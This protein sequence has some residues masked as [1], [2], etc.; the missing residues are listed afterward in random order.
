M[1]CVHHGR[2]CGE[3]P[4]V[5]TCPDGHRYMVRRLLGKGGFARVFRVAQLVREPKHHSA[6]DANTRALENSHVVA[7]ARGEH[8]SLHTLAQQKPLTAAACKHFALKVIS[9][10]RLGTSDAGRDALRNEVSIHRELKHPSIVNISSYW[11]DKYRIYLLLDLIEGPTLEELVRSRRRLAE[12]VAALYASQ[13]LEAMSYL[14]A[15]RIIH[16]DLK[17]ANVLLSK[18]LRRAYVCDFGLAIHSDNLKGSKTP[19][20][21]GTA[22]YFA[23]EVLTPALMSRLTKGFHSNKLSPPIGHSAKSDLWSMGV[24]LFS[25]LIG[26]GPFD[27]ED[28]PRTLRRI[29]TARFTFPIDIRL[30][31][32]AKSLVR[33][34]L[35]EDHR[36]R[37]TADEALQF[38]FFMISDQFLR[39]FVNGPIDEGRDSNETR[40]RI[41]T[42]SKRRDTPE[43]ANSVRSQTRNDDSPF[44]ISS[45][46]ESK[47]RNRRLS[48]PHPGHSNHSRERRISRNNQARL[49]RACHDRARS[50]N[51]TLAPAGRSDRRSSLA[52][53][54][55]GGNFSHI[56]TGTV[57]ESS[58]ISSSSRR[59]SIMETGMRNDTLNL[60]VT[61]SAALLK[62]RKFLDDDKTGSSPIGK[63]E[64]FRTVTTEVDGKKSAPPLVRRWMDYTSKYGFA[65]LMEDGRVGCCFN[66][67][68]IMFFVSEPTE[69][70]DVAYMPPLGT[71][72]AINKED[73]QNSKQ[74]LEISKKVCLCTLFADMIMDGGRGS[75]YDLPSACNVSFLK[76]DGDRQS[77]IPKAS[78]NFKGIVHVRDWARFRK[79]RATAFRLSNNNIHVKFDVGEDRCDD[80]VFSAT[81]STLFYR[82]AHSGDAFVCS[83]KHLGEFSAHSEYI[84]KQLQT[85]SRAITKFLE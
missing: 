85:C 42:S 74:Q 7:S 51:H 79:C 39:T 40:S 24:A 63:T 20:V 8:G 15:N 12:P 84:Y 67:G 57:D 35:T 71:D 64:R 26:Y 76:P 29:R 45:S 1:R 59:S 19:S 33:A 48:T 34:L 54:R 16:R 72:V 9:K 31:P 13:M 61:L 23:P 49:G 53:R 11:E 14:H 21:C 75:I 18:D 6:A 83:V 2:A 32:N 73:K 22:N 17:L 68:S 82:E 47:D 27:G 30:S 80:Y 81:D 60:S 4:V 37:P 5:L 52:H 10:C 38:P 50:T 3:P 46:S 66:D 25:M 28:V 56:A 78:N 77:Q 55:E 65:T 43:H 69:V 62:G 36:R 41:S 58:G 70:P 44:R